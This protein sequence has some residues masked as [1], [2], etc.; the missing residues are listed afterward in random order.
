M[1]NS[2]V[3][4]GYRDLGGIVG[5][6]NNWQHWLTNLMPVWKLGCNVKCE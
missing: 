6:E 1:I 5:L 2:R 4:E 3:M